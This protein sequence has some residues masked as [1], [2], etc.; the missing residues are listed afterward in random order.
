MGDIETRAGGEIGLETRGLAKIIKGYAIV[1]DRLSENLGGFKE[2]IAPSAVDR[3]M[4]ERIDLR[5]L[6]DHDSAKILGRLTAGTLRVSKD[7]RGLQIEIDPPETTIGLDIVESVRRRDVT[8][9]SF[10]FMALNDG[11]DAT[12]TP[13]TRTV[14]DMLIREVSIVTFPAYPDT[15]VALRSLAMRHLTPARSVSERLA[16]SQRRRWR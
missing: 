11:W 1:F 5:A 2:R 8:G 15:A 6:V 16:E 3:T 4:T 9:M 14:T 13:P 7:A 12:T 10:A